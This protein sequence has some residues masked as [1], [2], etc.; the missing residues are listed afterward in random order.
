MGNKRHERGW[1]WATLVLSS[2][3]IVALVF[4]FWELVENRFFRDLDYV[5]LHYLYIS[6]GVVSSVLLATWA[7]WF[8]TRQRRIAEAQLRKSHARY[9]GLLEASPEAVILYDRHLCVLEWN[10]SAERLYGWTRAEVCQCPLP[11]VPL[12]HHVEIQHFMHKVEYGEQV[13]DRET[14]RQNQMGEKIEVQL[15]LLPFREGQ[16]LYFLEITTDIRE[17]VRLRQRL[18]E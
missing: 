8:V 3:S 11:I 1:F 12:G 10:A 15:T 6:R 13:L 16:Q 4:A 7:A 9:R 5:S 17:R 14:V 2:I 18:I